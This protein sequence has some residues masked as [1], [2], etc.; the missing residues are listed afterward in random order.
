[1]ANTR[2]VQVYTDK[3]V[4]RAQSMS[5]E[6]YHRIKHM[7]KIELVHY[8]DQLCATAYKTGYTAGYEA[9]KKE[10]H[11]ALSDIPDEAK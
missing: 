8:L 3:A 4:E 5:K 6:E 1:M 2:T 9:G 10:N 11:I 7:P